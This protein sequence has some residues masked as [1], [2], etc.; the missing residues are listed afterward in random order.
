MVEHKMVGRRVGKGLTRK[1][2]GFGPFEQSE[3]HPQSTKVNS[4]H[5]EVLG[6]ARSVLIFDTLAFFS[7]N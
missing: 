1:V 3:Y 2:D 4:Q 6:S 7:P 5:C